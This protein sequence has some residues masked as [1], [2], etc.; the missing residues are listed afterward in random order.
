MIISPEHVR[1]NIKIQMEISYSYSEFEYPE[2]E[3]VL[4]EMGERMVEFM[5]AKLNDN[6]TNASGKLYNSLQ[7]LFSKEGQNLEISIS[8]EEYWKYVEN[9]TKAHWPPR[10]KIRE[11]IQTK[12]ILPEERNGKLPTVEQLTF[13]I[14]RAMAGLSPNQANCKNPNGGTAAQ[15][16]FWNSVEE[17]VKD[18]EQEI[19][20]ALEADLDRNIETMLLSIMF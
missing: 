8:L 6:G 7:Y 15:P 17:A 10:D 18:F 11:W 20:R 5:R 19:G 1:A 12:P 3:K 4:R 13:L 2:T 9:P 14:S 16:F